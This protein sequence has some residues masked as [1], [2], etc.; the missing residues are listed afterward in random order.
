MHTT[1]RRIKTLQNHI[2]PPSLLTRNSTNSIPSDSDD[3]GTPHQASSDKREMKRACIVEGC[4]T[5]FVK[6]YTT[7]IDVDAIDLGCTAVS[8]LLKK[9]KLDPNLVDEVIWGNVVV[10]VNSPNVAREIILQLGLPNSI[11]GVTVSRACLSGLEAILQGVRLIETGQ[12]ECVIAGGS[13]STSNCDVPIPRHLQHA[14]GKYTKGGGSKKGY[15]GMVEFAK[16]AGLPTS[17]VPEAPA[18]AE[19]STGK[20][21][22]YHADLMAEINN[23]SKTDQNRYAMTSHMRA[24]RAQQKGYLSEEIEPVVLKDGTVLDRDPMIRGKIDESKLDKLGPAFR[25]DGTISAATS[26]ALTDGGSAVLLMSES[27]ARKH[28]YA[29]DCSVESYHITGVD[30]FPQLLLAPAFAIPKV[31][32]RA[33]MKLQDVDYVEMHE[34][35]AAQVL[36]TLKTLD[37][38]EFAKTHLKRNQP[39]GKIDMEKLNPNGSSLSIGH[40]FAATGGRIV[41][42]TINELRRSQKESCLISICAAGSLGGAC[43]IKRRT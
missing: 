28:G 5:P 38:D 43:L 37:N 13:D 26:S 35:F 36:A 4:R 23:V 42:A 6:A 40:S 22:G 33:H 25:K 27:F 31:L 39:V 14:L 9:T 15:Q 21:M 11:S 34:A 29:T 1:Q 8:G 10:N 20:T 32:D 41:T 3:N 12:A 24:H 30:P 2:S 7:M 17:W 19:R 16:E 18:I